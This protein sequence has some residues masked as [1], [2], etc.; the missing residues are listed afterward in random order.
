MKY[1]GNNELDFE[2][3]MPST[4]YTAGKYFEFEVSGKN[5]TTNKD[6]Y[7]DI[8]LNHGVDNPKSRT[9][10]L[11]DKFLKFRLVEVENYGESNETENE[12]IASRSFNT[13]NNTRLHKTTID[14]NTT[15]DVR[16]IYRLYAWI[17]NDVVIGNVNQDYTETEWN[18]VYASIS[19]TV[20]GDFTDKEIDLPG[21]LASTKIMNRYNSSGQDGLYAVNTDGDLYD[22]TD[23]TQTIREY[24][25]SG[26]TPNNYIYFNGNELWRIVGVF[27][28]ELKIVKDTTLSN[29]SITNYTHTDPETSSTTE[30]N[31]K[32][33]EQSYGTRLFWNKTIVSQSNYTDWTTAGLQYYLN[34]SNNTN[35]Y[36]SSINYAYKS[37]IKTNTTYYLGNVT[38][39]NCSNVCRIDGTANDVRTQERGNIICDSSISQNSDTVSCNI[40]SENQVT[41]N[42]AIALLYA[43][44][45]GYANA[46]NLWEVNLNTTY[47]N[48]FSH[49]NWIVSSS[50]IVGSEWL[51][52][53]SS[54][55]SSYY[56]RPY[57]VLDLSFGD[58][59]TCG[60]ESCGIAVRP[61][62]YLKS[63]TRIYSGDGT[64]GNPYRVVE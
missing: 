59:E 32:K 27:D 44:D 45:I 21:E 50:S 34:D 2:G 10:R 46:V 49:N 29:V 28:G 11:D 17:S 24:R 16:H 14:K 60:G 13:I 61:T 30:F 63:D 54:Y 39:S 25:Y 7:Y 56:G 15:T 42:G 36:Y 1:K 23:E 22:S 18:D 40:W 53:P 6:I 57:G 4:T 52:S 37:L 51:L 26:A 64:Q 62:L 19:V 3:A 9:T 48:D 38:M 8:V 55:F 41:W 12:I 31:L 47:D 58:I 5:T 20:N 33:D 43:S 35:S